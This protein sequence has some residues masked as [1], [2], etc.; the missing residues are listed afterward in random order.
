MCA[1]ITI[2]G[3]HQPEKQLTQCA[4]MLHFS[5]SAYPLLDNTIN[6]LVDYVSALAWLH[7]CPLPNGSTGPCM[8]VTCP[9]EHTHAHARAHVRSAPR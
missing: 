2:L 3:M 4:H 7:G 6:A 5:F 8:V 9:C 1:V